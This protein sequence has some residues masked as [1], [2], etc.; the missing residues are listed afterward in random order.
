MSLYKNNL[1]NF[2]NTV[3]ELAYLTNNPE[4]TV[5]KVLE[6]INEMTPENIEKVLDK[7]EKD[8]AHQVRA[9]WDSRDITCADKEHPI[10]KN[11]IEAIR[12]AIRS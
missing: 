8:L 4:K 3:M 6:S 7:L 11:I 2:A 12:G 1:F 10:V 9:F 5:T